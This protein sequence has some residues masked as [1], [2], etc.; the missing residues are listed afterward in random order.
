M[1]KRSKSRNRG[2]QSTAALRANAVQTFK[3][4]DY[5]GA[6]AIWE[7]LIRQTPDAV[8]LVD[9]AEAHF[10]LALQVLA[11]PTPQFA[12]AREHLQAA[13]KY[14]PQDPRFPYHL[15]LAAQRAGDL[16]AAVPAYQQARELS[17]EFAQRA[18]YPLCVAVLEQGHDPSKDPA[19]AM[20]TPSEQARIQSLTVF[21]RRPFRVPASAPALLRGMAA[22][23]EGDL[24]AARALFTQAAWGGPPENGAAHYYLGVLAALAEDWETARQEWGQ[25]IASGWKSTALEQNLGELHHRLAEEYAQAGAFSDAIAVAQEAR[26]H[27][28]DDKALGELLDYLKQHQ[29]YAAAQQA[30]WQQAQQLWQEA[31]VL[32]GG[33]FR[34]AYNLALI[35]EQTG[36]FITAAEMWREALRRRPRRDDHPDAINDAQVARLWRRAAEAYVKSGE[37]EEAIHVYKMA[38]KWAPNNLETRM[39]LVDGLMSDGRLWAAENELQRILELDDNH[40]PAL[41]RMAEVQSEVR[42][43]GMFNQA[44]HYWMRVLQID[45]R[46]PEARQE[47]VA[48]YLET[49]QQALDWGRATDALGHFQKVLEYDPDNPDA[50]AFIGGCYVRMKDL[51]Q[52]REYLSQAVFNSKAT[53]DTFHL[54]MNIV[55][56]EKLFDDISAYAEQIESATAEP[57]IDFY[58]AQARTAFY[59]DFPQQAAFYLERAKKL[60][61]PGHPINLAI[62]NV[63]LVT[64]D[65]ELAEPYLE[66]A[67]ANHEVPV[68]VQIACAMLAIRRE[69]V[70]QARK[71]LREAQKLARRA[72][73]D[74]LLADIQMF[75]SLLTA[76]PFIFD[77]MLQT[78]G[79]I[80]LENVFKALRQIATAPPPF[81]HSNEEYYDD[82]YFGF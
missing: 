49:G 19:W 28:P 26:R 42:F 20:L 61:L 54:V 37:Y 35:Y 75:E 59:Q 70:P 4:E 2:A 11:A 10:R 65:W 67:L 68:Q 58:V 69:Q 15:G 21:Q 46:H 8:P 71:H 81:G 6:L 64:A 78:A 77:M 82:D 79:E 57:L 73:D 72:K 48:H 80:G 27:K 30:D 3:R 18:A 47:L 53:V 29:A 1:S 34:L 74:S 33:S 55:R 40:I 36:N 22:L 66:V 45:P 9:L 12:Q 76:P 16:D 5:T 43:W 52:A 56:L 39:M 62:A 7:R 60:A 31:N 13:M 44:P 41:M 50:Q 23:D 24:V 63:F 51:P 32:S 38:V 14:A 17:P 25:A